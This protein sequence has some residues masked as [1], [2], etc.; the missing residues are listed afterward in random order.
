MS[1]TMLFPASTTVSITAI[2]SSDI[3]AICMQ[4]K[5]GDDVCTAILRFHKGSPNTIVWDRIE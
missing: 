2:R 3:S 5:S 4:R 1:R